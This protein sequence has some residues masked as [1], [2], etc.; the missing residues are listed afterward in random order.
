M[1]LPL[2]DR[3]AATRSYPF[4]GFALA[5]TL[6][7]LLNAAI[8]LAVENKI[9]FFM[10]SIFTAVSAAVWGAWPGVVTAI[11]TNVLIEVVNGFPGVHLPF[12]ICGVATAIIVSAFARRKAYQ[13]L[14]SSILCIA[15]VTLA[16]S[17]LGALIA[18]FVFGGGT[19]SN[20]DDI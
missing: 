3:L 10:D 7:P 8:S 13:S 15:T 14:L 19:R 2:I 17:L 12:A 11:M 20:I 5:V 16:N 18:T 6:M 4:I 1:Q 9:P